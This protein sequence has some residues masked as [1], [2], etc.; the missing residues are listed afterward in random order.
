MGYRAKR[1][2]SEPGER[3]IGAKKEGTEAPSL[4]FSPTLSEL[5][6]CFRSLPLLGACSQAEFS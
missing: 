6:F 2:I 1:K 5:D 3:G 4:L